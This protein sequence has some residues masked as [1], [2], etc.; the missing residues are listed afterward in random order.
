MRV[1]RST[2]YKKL[3][4]RVKKSKSVREREGGVHESEKQL[5]NNYIREK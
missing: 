2:E 1:K 4:K 5:Y 3:S